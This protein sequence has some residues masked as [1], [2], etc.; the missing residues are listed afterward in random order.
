MD[1]RKFLRNAGLGGLAAGGLAAPA[2]AQEAPKVTWRLTSS[3]PK[4]LD[5]I[6]G[7]AEVLSQRISE[8]TDGNFTIQCFPAG[9]LVPG[10][11]AADEV[12][13]GNIEA[14]HTVGYYYWGKDPTW[15]VAA[16][17]PFSLSA[18]GINAW[19]YHGGGIDLYNE[20]LADKNIFALPGGNTGVQ[21]GGWFRKEINTVEDLKG[22]KFRVGGFAGK[23]L[24]KLGVVPQQIA[25]GDIYP[26]LEKGTIDGAEWVGPYDDEKLGFYKV[27]PYYYYPGWWEGGP[28]VHFMFGKA[29]YEGLPKNYQSLLRSICQGVDADMLQKYDYKNPTAIKSLVANG[30]QLRPFSPEILSACFD[31]ANEVYADMEATNPAFAKIWQSIKAFRSENYTWAQIAE[32]NYDTFMMMQQNAGKL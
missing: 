5:T 16:A 25:G 4:S 17:V 18:R 29:A 21:M 14:C 9:E 2:L 23:V 8:A 20:F 6:Y 30:T 26:S 13:A 31:A 27:A 28:T 32:Y 15:A 1:R 11:Q 10:L 19:H 7:A 12:S 22:L 24:E 3:F